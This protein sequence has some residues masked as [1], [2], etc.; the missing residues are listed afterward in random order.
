MGA[1]AMMMQQQLRAM[2]EQMQEMQ[3]VQQALL[4]RIE[5]L[6]GETVRVNG[7]TR[8]SS[9][10]RTADSAP[11]KSSSAKR[12]HRNSRP[13]SAPAPAPSD[14]DTASVAA[15]ERPER[16]ARPTDE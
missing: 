4:E 2:Q 8:R 3:L 7:H 1:S 12:P 6:T 5:K 16:P 9:T 15:T 10:L 14:S 13:K 11:Q